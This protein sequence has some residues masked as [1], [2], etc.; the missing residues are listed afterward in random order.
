MSRGDEVVQGM[1]ET[2][3]KKLWSPV[4]DYPREIANLYRKS[5]TGV[6]V[7]G[8]GGWGCDDPCKRLPERNWEFV[9]KV[10]HSTPVNDYP[11][12]N[13]VLN[14]KLPPN[15]GTKCKDRASVLS[16][17][18]EERLH[19]EVVGK[20]FKRGLHFGSGRRSLVSRPGAPVAPRRPSLWK[21]RAQ[22]VAPEREMLRSAF[23]RA[24]LDRSSFTSTC[25][26]A[27][28]QECSSASVRPRSSRNVH[29]RSSRSVHPCSSA[30]V[31]T[32]SVRPNCSAVSVRPD[33]SA[34]SVRPNRSTVN[35]RP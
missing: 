23:V 5:N 28:V 18:G 24:K 35:V 7:V 22:H 4:N 27:F 31:Q 16:W 6:P 8:E 19:L 13:R 14:S 10:Q 15:M 9:Q 29:P 12:K 25:E 1:S 17:K 33:C 20:G 3:E 11:V 21:C 2:A 32:T 30:F 34:A 26:R